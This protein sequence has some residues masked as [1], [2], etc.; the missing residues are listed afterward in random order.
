MVS[1]MRFGLSSEHCTLSLRERAQA[2]VTDHQL[3][4]VMNFEDIVDFL[5]DF[6]IGAL[7]GALCLVGVMVPVVIGSN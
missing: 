4:S 6:A 2:G 3:E 1:C 5:I 7:A